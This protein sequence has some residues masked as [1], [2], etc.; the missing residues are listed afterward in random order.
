M[1][2]PEEFAAIRFLVRRMI[3]ENHYSAHQV[4][5]CFS[6]TDQAA[7]AKVLAELSGEEISAPPPPRSRRRTRHK[8]NG[9]L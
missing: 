6:R 2:T 1:M 9:M 5:E 4:T 7:V 3:E 8:R